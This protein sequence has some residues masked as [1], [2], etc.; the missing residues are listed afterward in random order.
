MIDVRGGGVGV[1]VNVGGRDGYFGDYNL[2]HAEGGGILYDFTKPFGDLLD[3]QADVA[4]WELHSSGTTAV[5]PLLSVPHFASIARGDFAL[6]D[7]RESLRRTSFGPGAGASF[8]DLGEAFATRDNLLA[9]PSFESGL[10]SW[11]TNTAGAAI[12]SDWD[13]ALAFDSGTDRF[14]FA[15]QTVSLTAS[16]F[17]AGEIDAED[18]V[19][20]FGGRVTVSADAEIN[21]IYL[22]LTFLDG[23]GSPVGEATTIE[24]LRTFLRWEL[25][26]GRVAVPAGARQATFRFDADVEVSG[27]APAQFDGAFLS[28]QSEALAADAGAYFGTDFASAVEPDAARIAVRFPDLYTDWERDERR[29]ILWDTFGNVGESDIRIDLY[30]DSADGPA[31]LLNIGTVPDTGAFSWTPFDDSG[32]GYGT[33]GLRIVLSLDDVPATYDVASESF[34]VPESGSN[35]YVNIGGDSDLGDNEYTA[36][37]GS[38]RHTGKDPS[39][40]KPNPVNLLRAYELGGGDTLSIDPGTYILIDEISLSGSQVTLL[41]SDQ[42]FTMQG[43]QNA[44]SEL[45]GASGGFAV[46]LI[47]LIDADLMTITDLTLTQGQ[48][49]L[50]IIDDTSGLTTDDL[51]FNNPSRYGVYV[52]D[53]YD[54]TLAGATITGAGTYGV[55]V[56][57]LGDRFRTFTLDGVT[58]TGSGKH[59]IYADHTFE[60]VLNINGAELSGN[61]VNGIYIDGFNNTGT[62]NDLVVHDN[63]FGVRTQGTITINRANVFDNLGGPDPNLE[64]QPVVFPVN[65]V[66]SP[67][68]PTPP[69]P[70]WATNGEIPSMFSIALLKVVQAGDHT[71][72]F[73]EVTNYREI[74]YNDPGYGI[75]H[76][77]STTLTVSESTVSGHW[78]GVTAQ[79]LVLTDSEVFGN[80]VGVNARGGTLSGNYIHDNSIGYTNRTTLDSL[81]NR[82]GRPFVTKLFLQYRSG[83]S[84]LIENNIFAHNNYEPP[85]WHEWVTEFHNPCEHPSAFNFQWD[86]TYTKYPN[87]GINIDD[88]G[89]FV[90][91][92]IRGNTLYDESLIAP[93]SVANF[94]FENNIAR[95]RSIAYS[96]VAPSSGTGMLALPEGTA[97]TDIDYNLYFAV[98][99]LAPPPMQPLIYNPG[100]APAPLDLAE[101]RSLSSTRDANSITADPLFLDWANGDFH[102]QSEF[103]SWKMASGSFTPDAATSPGIDAGDPADDF[104]NELESNGGYRNIGAYGNTAQASLSNPE[105]IQVTK[106]R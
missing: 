23:S 43:A 90:D 14:G 55:F 29:D 39:A 86:P 37:A 60:E 40:P 88:G 53:A 70:A 77:G 50:S 15:E 27:A 42:G 30:Q 1:V 68:N 103:G 20:V 46:N 3:L 74:R 69:I 72:Y 12:G 28:L 99:Y 45:V 41:G 93:E 4:R 106:R 6:P 80:N 98:F 25:V 76:A 54:N 18:L 91:L 34:N 51:V 9:N 22:T 81:T 47:N 61:S 52:H 82:G 78:V 11:A 26:G 31:F 8:I 35:Y 57:K 75:N 48:I 59:G 56:D 67:A 49:G 101:I 24:A 33:Y 71:I 44:V 100:G 32:I 85:I 64:N 66:D 63:K 73:H 7:V 21:A 84:L 17:T 87:Y 95:A 105:F 36:A 104:S 13:G 58:V 83:T 10:A 5:N 92:I 102:L 94:V 79:N 19:A 65:C 62:W 16:G 96:G 38:N 2:L 89:S 97:T